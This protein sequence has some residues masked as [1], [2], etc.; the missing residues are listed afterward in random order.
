MRRAAALVT[1]LKPASR[2]FLGAPDRAAV[3]ED[4]RWSE[5][6]GAQLVSCCSPQ[7]PPLLTRIADAP[8][9]LYVLGDVGSL[10]V[11]QLAMVGSRNPT[12]GGVAT[13]PFVPNISRK[14]FSIVA[15][16]ASVLSVIADQ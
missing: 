7:Y 14:D 10:A 15:P 8:P 5:A 6:N 2:A 3:E 1:P 12:A 13:G 16:A 9:V 4:L 11:P